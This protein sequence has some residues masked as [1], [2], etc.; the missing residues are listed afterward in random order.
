MLSKISQAGN[1][2]SLELLRNLWRHLQLEIVQRSA[3]T[4]S[5]VLAMTPAA[6]HRAL[7]KFGL[8]DSSLFEQLRIAYESE[9]NGEPADVG[10][11]LPELMHLFGAL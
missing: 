5:V 10:P 2:A 9:I 7:P 4:R 8:P 6:V 11:L 3:A 1:I